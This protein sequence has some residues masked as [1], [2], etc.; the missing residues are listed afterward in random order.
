MKGAEKGFTPHS[1]YAR[2]SLLVDG[3]A[4]LSSELSVLRIIDANLNRVGE[5]LRFLEDVA[6]LVLDDVSLTEELKSMRHHLLEGD[7]KL[8]KKLI[9]ARDAEGDVGAFLQAPGE[10]RERELPQLVVANSMRVKQSLRVLEEMSK[11]AKLTP[12]LDTE[13]FK[14]ARFKF[15]TIEK[16]LLA[17]LKDK[18]ES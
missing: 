9:E 2:I 15:Y 7:L 10:E 14:K 1:R 6:R 4:D 8:V 12:K 3:G 16:E 18:V 11:L 5:G 13:K 17:K